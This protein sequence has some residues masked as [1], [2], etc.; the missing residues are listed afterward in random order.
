MQEALFY[1][2]AE[3]SRVKCKLCPKKCTIAPGKTGSC[4]VRENVNGTLFSQVYGKVAAKALD[5]IEKKPLYHFFP[6]KKVLS[7]GEVGCNLHCSFCQNYTISQCS[8][9]K[10]QSFVSISSDE[11][12]KEAQGIPGNI[13]IAYTYNEPF[14]F[15]EFMFDT[16]RLAKDQGLKNVVVSNGYVNTKPLKK[17]LPYID[18]FNIDLKAFDKKFYKKEAKGKLKPVLKSLEIIAQS[19]SHLEITNLVIPGL[20]DNEEQFE[21]MVKWISGT[22]GPQVPLHLSCYFPH[23]KKELPPTPDETIFRLLNIAKKH[24]THVYPGNLP[25]NKDASTFCSGCGALIVSR[26]P[27]QATITQTGFDGICTQCG[28]PANIHTG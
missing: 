28:E 19:H 17:I 26:K 14:T 23:Y 1:K 22:L 12:V 25:D 2:K 15:Y 27:G 16:A 9:S 6:G 24:L 11:I 21:A 4:R 13:G 5:P 8:A 3:K 18:A 20:N 7:I 10:Y